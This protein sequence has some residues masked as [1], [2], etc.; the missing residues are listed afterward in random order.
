M[1]SDGNLHAIGR[2]R[3]VPPCHWL[4]PRWRVRETCMLLVETDW[5]TALSLVDP[6][7]ESDVSLHATGR[8][9]LAPSCHWMITRWRVMETC[10]L[11]VETD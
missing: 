9:R 8:N 11:L 2:N 6:M 7:V 3:L 1:E 5:Y 4:I 10:I